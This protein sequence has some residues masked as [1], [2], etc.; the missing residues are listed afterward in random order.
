MRRPRPCAR[1][2]LP[3]RPAASCLD[4]RRLDPSGFDAGHL[5]GPSLDGPSL[6]SPSLDAMPSDVWRPDPSNLAAKYP[7]PDAGCPDVRSLDA[8]RLDR[9][10]ASPDNLAWRETAAAILPAGYPRPRIGPSD[11]VRIEKPA[12]LAALDRAYLAVPECPGS[13]E[14]RDQTCRYSNRWIQ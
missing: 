2:L 1:G 4:G 7:A 14:R 13:L 6:D 3:A 11:R 8:C 5:D 10:T 12:A 9:S